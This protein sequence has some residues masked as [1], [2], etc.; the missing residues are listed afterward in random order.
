MAASVAPWGSV[1][2]V[3]LAT[4]GQQDGAVTARLP[5]GGF[6]VVWVDN[7]AQGEGALPDGGNA[8]SDI[9]LRLFNADGSARGFETTVNTH[10]RGWQVD[11]DVAVL[12]DGRIAVT[13]TDGAGFYGGAEHPGSG[14]LGD[15]DSR[16]VRLRVFSDSAQPLG[17]EQLLNQTVSM[18]QLGSDAVALADGRLLVGW[19]D[20]SSSC[21][22][23]GCGG[24]PSVKAR[25][26]AS[27]GNA[28]RSE[29]GWA[30]SWNY[31]PA[32]VALT[33]GGY[34]AVWLSAYY[35]DPAQ[36][37][38]RLHDSSGGALATEYAFATGAGAGAQWAGAG[39]GGGGLVLAWTLRD[40]SSGDGSGKS[41]AVQLFDASG[42]KAGGV[43]IANSTT[44]GDQENVRVA[45]T[46][47]GGFVVAWE[48]TT[49]PD[50]SGI[51]TRQLRLQLFDAQ[52]HARGAEQLVE[53][54]DA[55]LQLNDVVALD[56]GGFAVAWT[57][58]SWIDVHVRAYAAS[59]QPL[60]DTVVVHGN[61]GFQNQA[62]LTALE[63]GAFNVT[64]SV[65]YDGYNGGDGSGAGLHT[66]SFVTRG[67]TLAGDADADTLKDSPLDD[68]IDGGAGNDRIHCQ[69]GRDQVAGGDGVD[70]LV[71]PVPLADV[72][73][74][75]SDWQLKPG[76]PT[77]G[78]SSVGEL[79]I[80]GVERV[81]LADAMYAFDTL[82]GG[83][84]WQAASL[85]HLAFAALPSSDDLSRWT[86]VA[87]RSA[88][89]GTLA[90]A[91]L[92]D[93]VPT[94]ISDEVLVDFLYLR[95]TGQKA[96]AAT[97]ATYA[98]QVRPGGTWDDQGELLA[99]AAAL[100]AN[101]DAMLMAGGVPFAGSVQALDLA[102]WAAA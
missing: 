34:S 18:D 99:W 45:A 56:G 96:D 44:A 29:M 16:S 71:L 42:A 20:W 75:L 73:Q 62:R 63:D 54:D 26:Y 36:I 92:H 38:V 8:A 33:G 21:N 11:P 70:T 41:V 25:L 7:D 86:A 27:D 40:A 52:G 94:A 15:A 102:D 3:N 12:A 31:A 60:G 5:D 57:G 80:S 37:R 59:G 55:A 30:D 14:T 19:E 93:V 50:S 10:T 49:L 2:S 51:W 22:S 28:L 83:K 67:L 23:N 81:Q 72:L 100:P 91:L 13:W 97:V 61:G 74:H 69:G 47:D 39:L 101:A 66:R 1:M 4:Y 17:S 32:P 98:D 90:A 6:V 58:R 87:D 43:I 95:L 53:A 88:D 77:A 84:T 64:W 89:F 85:L 9:R 46:A 48:S 78:R 79:L 68:R 76:G 82:V 65:S 35:M 24:G